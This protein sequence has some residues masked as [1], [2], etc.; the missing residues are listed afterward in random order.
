MER[1]DRLDGR[2]LFMLDLTEREATELRDVLDDLASGGTPTA[3][4]RA[5]LGR[6]STQVREALEEDYDPHGGG[7]RA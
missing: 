7:L 4:G 3:S 1:V 5:L 2:S 6:V